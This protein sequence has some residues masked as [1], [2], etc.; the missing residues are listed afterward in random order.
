MKLFAA[1]VTAS[2]FMGTSVNTMTFYGWPDNSPPGG[3]IAYPSTH[4]TAG[5]VGTYQDPITFAS[6]NKE[7]KPGTKLYIPSLKKYVVMEDYCVDCG[8][9]WKK[10]KSH[11]DV[12]MNSNS[13]FK[14]QVLACEN[15]WTP[16]G[17]VQIVQNPASN[18]TVNITPLFSTSTGK[19]L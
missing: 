17:S 18:L 14:K 12:W 6:D 9:D 5:G 11:I 7:F 1:A 15:K 3:A 8:K 10:G 4:K 13:K 19:C 2:L 16:D